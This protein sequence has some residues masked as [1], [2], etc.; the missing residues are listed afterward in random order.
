MM[1]TTC[2]EVIGMGSRTPPGPEWSIIRER[3]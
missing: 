2:G 3:A 1:P